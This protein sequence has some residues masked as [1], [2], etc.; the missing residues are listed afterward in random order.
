[1]VKNKDLPDSGRPYKHPH[2]VIFS[3]SLSL[4]DLALSRWVS[5]VFS[6]SR[7]CRSSWVCFLDPAEA[8][9]QQVPPWAAVCMSKAILLWITTFLIWICSSFKAWMAFV[10]SRKA[11]FLKLVKVS[12]L[13]VI[14]VVPTEGTNKA[15]IYSYHRNTD[16]V[17]LACK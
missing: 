10:L 14:S 6:L 5:C 9:P 2:M 12:T 11:C 1:M 13:I 4:T 15:A 3:L 16:L 17:H 7:W 8:G